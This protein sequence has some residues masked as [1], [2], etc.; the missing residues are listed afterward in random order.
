MSWV[1]GLFTADIA[2]KAVDGIYNGVDMLVYTD[3]EKAVAMQKQV[4]TKLKMLPLF[5]PFKL[6]QRVI[7]IGFTINFF[8]AFWIGV[9]LVLWLP[10]YFD[11][12]MSIVK[13]FGLFWI[14]GTIVT[15]YFTG[16]LINSFKGKDK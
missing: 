3:E 5:A 6:A 11:A 4:E 7:A 15:F 8:I 9:V 14:M 10:E 1:S 16:G 12:Y 2:T 13:E